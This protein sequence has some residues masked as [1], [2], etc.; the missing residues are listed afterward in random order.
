M[1]DP[2]SI[3][4]LVLAIPVVVQQLMIYYSETKDA[5]K[6]VQ[7]FAAELFALRGILEYIESTR[8]SHT[9]NDVYKYDSTEFKQMLADTQDTLAG[10]Q[11]VLEQKKSRMGQLVQ[12]AT[13]SQKK[14]EVH[15]HLTRIERLK[16]G[17]MVV[18]MGDSL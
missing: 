12:R 17:F 7:Q 3:A 5:K 4:G 2:L 18:M 15:E 14:K 9:E 1:A 11:A 16:S 13:W 6:D 8:V 10:V